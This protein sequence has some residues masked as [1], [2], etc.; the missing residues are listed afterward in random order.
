[1]PKFATPEQIIEATCSAFNAHAERIGYEKR[2]SAW[3]PVHPEDAQNTC[4]DGCPKP[5]YQCRYLCIYIICQHGI[6]IDSF[7]GGKAYKM[8][9]A[10]AGEHFGKSRNGARR[11]ILRACEMIGEKVFSDIYGD[12][13]A[14]LRRQG[15]DLWNTPQHMNCHAA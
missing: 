6:Y 11:C 1:M 7:G 12:A 10:R 13:I 15:L 9:Y 5:V 4:E 3:L 14:D 2:S 8:S